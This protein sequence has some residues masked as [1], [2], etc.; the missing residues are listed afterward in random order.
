[1]GEIGAM[2]AMRF[3]GHSCVT[4]RINRVDFE[5]PIR[6]GDIALIESYV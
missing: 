2:S 6:V 5:Q 4:V 1:M 3:S